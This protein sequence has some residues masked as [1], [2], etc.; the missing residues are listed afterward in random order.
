MDCLKWWTYN[1]RFEIESLLGLTRRF[2]ENKFLF[3]CTL[4]VVAA[5]HL[6]TNKNK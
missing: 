4:P 6:R 5:K 2:H 1:F 3:R